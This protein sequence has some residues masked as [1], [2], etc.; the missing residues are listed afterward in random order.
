MIILQYEVVIFED[1]AKALGEALRL[2]QVLQTQ[3][4]LL[5]VLG[6]AHQHRAV[7]G[8]K[9]GEAADGQHRV[10]QRHV[11]P[12]GQRGRAQCL[13]HHPHLL[14]AGAVFAALDPAGAVSGARY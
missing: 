7:A 9:L 6:A 12:V 8:G 14:G 1:L 13:A 10:Q 4:V 5:V 11:L 2:G 3:A